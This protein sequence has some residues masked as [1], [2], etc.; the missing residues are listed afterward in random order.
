MPFFLRLAILKAQESE[1]HIDDYARTYGS[2]KNRDYHQFLLRVGLRG[3][4]ILNYKNPIDSGELGF[5]SGFLREY[6]SD[7]WLVV[8]VGANAGDFASWVLCSSRSIR[9][10]SYEPSPSSCAKCKINLTPYSDRW[11]LVEKAI[12]DSVEA[13]TLWDYSIDAGSV[14]ASMY[15]DVIE[16]IHGSAAAPI[17]IQQST[18]DQELIT[19]GMKICLLKYDIE[20]HELKALQ[21]SRKLIG[22]HK[23]PAILI[24]F[25]EMNALSGSSFFMI[26][27]EIGPNYLPYRLLPGGELLPLAGLPLVMTE[28]YAF[29]NIVFLLHRDFA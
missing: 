29:Q 12:G 27:K 15:R 16:K 20:G 1:Y 6:D 19:T 26:S 13:A 14:H 7:G 22:L 9:V 2:L 5:L 25:N 8:D 4:G 21:G 28:L 11:S 10:I 23:P 3:L 18:L 17:A 24:E